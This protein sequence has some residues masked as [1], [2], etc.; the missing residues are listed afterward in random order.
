MFLDIHESL[1]I[2]SCI[3]F[4]HMHDEAY[5]FLFT[6]ASQASMSCLTYVKCINRFNH[7]HFMSSASLKHAY[8]CMLIHTY[9]VSLKQII[10]CFSYSLNEVYHIIIILSTICIT[11][12]HIIFL[13]VQMH[14]IMFLLLYE[15]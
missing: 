9:H 4:I 12:F 15:Y 13:L 5:L 11:Q 1:I 2:S 7:V 6:Y 10:L 8:M 14:H 3:S